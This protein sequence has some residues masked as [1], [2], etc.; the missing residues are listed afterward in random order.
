MEL[1][2]SLA[3]AAVIS[4]ASTSAV[5]TVTADD[6]CARN[7]KVMRQLYAEHLQALNVCGDGNYFFRALSMCLH[8]HQGNHSSLRK[9][10][11]SYVSK[12]SDAAHPADRATLRRRAQEVATDGF[13]PW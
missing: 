5:V 7:Q 2:G 8:G 3:A 11:A 10:V 4:A 1:C 13:W 12:Q 6:I 9:L